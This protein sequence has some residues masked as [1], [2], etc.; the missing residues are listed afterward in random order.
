MLRK[1]I[2]AIS[3]KFLRTLVIICAVQFSHSSLAA[4]CRKIRFAQFEKNVRG[5]EID[6]VWSGTRVT[7]ASLKSG[8]DIYFGYYNA[9][10]HL[11]I[12]QYHRD[13]E[14]VCVVS[15][16]SV[17][18]GWDSH[19][20]V[21]LALDS[22][23][24]LHVAG[25]MHASP[26][27][28]AKSTHRGTIEGIE[29]TRMVGKDEDRTTY[30]TFLSQSDG[31][32]LFLYRECGSGDGR[33]IV[34]RYVNGSWQRIQQE[35]FTDRW[36]NKPVSAYP[37]SW[38]L[39]PDGMFHAAIVWRSKPDAETNFAVSYVKTPNFM[40][41]VSHDGKSLHL[42]LSLDTADKVEWTGQ[43]S[44]LLNS[45]QVS[46]DPSGQPI[47]T[48]T[49]YAANGHNAIFAARPVG[50]NWTI[51]KIAESDHQTI[52]AGKGS[53]P[54]VPRFRNLMFGDEGRSVSFDIGF[55]GGATQRYP[56]SPIT[57]LPSGKPIPITSNPTMSVRL[58][59]IAG[60]EDA[61]ESI[62]KVSTSNRQNLALDSSDS[63]HYIT[64]ASN[65]DQPRRC[66]ALAPKAC[67][68]PP[69]PLYFMQYER[70][71]N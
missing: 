59:P 32:L 70:S 15:L 62:I 13:T 60:I 53:L 34:N 43:N 31:T 63:L 4:D 28:Y 3:D 66:T 68:P 39:G 2:K 46:F 12:A 42:P 23:G 36:N 35:L 61:Q 27:V 11:T 20:S 18:K 38:E 47:L 19:N 49:K 30:P 56:L 69:S 5:A 9:A 40:N 51:T 16:N 48:Y 65:R 55:S 6:R 17:F 22:N 58:S 71:S 45:A 24:Y 52:L 57:L 44:G 1:T 37:S 41:W 14:Q 29:L 8:N 50:N 33:W 26:L 54:D 67:N 64:Q 10:R 21:V 25:N 7:Y